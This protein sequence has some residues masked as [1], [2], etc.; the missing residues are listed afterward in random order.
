MTG[1]S[2]LIQSLAKSLT[3]LRLKEE[4]AKVKSFNEAYN[5]V[6]MKTVNPK[7]VSMQELYGYEHPIT[8][9]CSCGW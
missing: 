1:K 5:R 7:S 4:A 9:V 6:K 2:V 3:S 8:Q